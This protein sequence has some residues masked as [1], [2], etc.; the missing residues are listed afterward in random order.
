ME[1]D[2]PKLHVADPMYKNGKSIDIICL[3]LYLDSESR[4]R[5]RVGDK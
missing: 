1:R 2:V 5:P 4:L 3:K